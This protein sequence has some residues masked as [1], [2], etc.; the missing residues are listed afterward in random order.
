[1]KKGVIFIHTKNF[2]V[3][4]TVVFLCIIHVEGPL[5]IFKENSPKLITL[6]A[7][8]KFIEQDCNVIMMLLR[9]ATTFATVFCEDDNN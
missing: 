7:L 4:I 5:E 6:D 9:F 1:M 8:Y 3:Y 2:L